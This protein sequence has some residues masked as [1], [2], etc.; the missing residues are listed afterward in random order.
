M[1]GRYAHG[2]RG[3]VWADCVVENLVDSLNRG[4][5]QNAEDY[6]AL[7]SKL[8]KD[9]TNIVYLYEFGTE[10][11][12]AVRG[13]IQGVDWL[14]IFGKDGIMETAF[15]PRDVEGYIVNRGFRPLGKIGEVVRWKK[16][17]SC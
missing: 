8:I 4:I 14:V 15:P 2:N 17:K 12:Y 7:V 10:R 13:S 1:S 6:N 16:S 5:W 3:G 9:D 11:Y